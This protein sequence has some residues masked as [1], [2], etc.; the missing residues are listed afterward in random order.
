[1]TGQTVTGQTV[2]GRTVTGR[3]VTRRTAGRHHVPR[4]ETRPRPPSL[5]LADYPAGDGLFPGY[6]VGTFV[7]PW[8]RPPGIHSARRGRTRRGRRRAAAAA[9]ACMGVAAFVAALALARSS[10]ASGRGDN[11][12]HRRPTPRPAVTSPHTVRPTITPTAADPDRARR[13]AGPHRRPVAASSAP[14]TAPSVTAA[15]P[16][17]SAAPRRPPIEVSYLVVSQGPGGFQGEIQV[18][19]NTKQQIANWQIVVAFDGDAVG[20][21]TN[22]DGYV[23]NGILMLSPAS[24]AQVAPPD[25][26]VLDIF[27]VAA[28]AQTVPAVCAFDGIACG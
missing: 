5:L 10:P 16:S 7:Q 25:G 17:P 13:T 6:R 26:G 22:A 2:T 20:S 28:G 27:F 24:P 21:F 3:T 14:V 11:A 12:I 23:S 19:N 4:G 9:L 8:R 15:S 18:T 1:V